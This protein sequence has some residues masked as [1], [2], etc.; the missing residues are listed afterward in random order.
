M[1]VYQ[2]WIW[3][4]VSVSIFFDGGLRIAVLGIQP[5]ESISIRTGYLP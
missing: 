2:L 3:L 5:T 1:S 4:W